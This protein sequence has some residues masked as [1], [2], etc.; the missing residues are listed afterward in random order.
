MRGYENY[1]VLTMEKE[2]NQYNDSL[3]FLFAEVSR[4][5]ICLLFVR[6]SSGFDRNRQ[7]WVDS[8]CLNEVLAC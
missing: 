4:N 8:G 7:D 2:Q 6:C 5:C 1:C 3:M